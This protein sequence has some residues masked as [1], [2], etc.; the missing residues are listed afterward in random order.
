M[1]EGSIF[2]CLTKSTLR[3]R[4]GVFNTA[5]GFIPNHKTDTH[6]IGEDFNSVLNCKT[7]RHKNDTIRP[8]MCSL[9]SRHQ[10]TYRLFCMFKTYWFRNYIISNNPFFSV[11]DAIIIHINPE[12]IKFCQGI[13]N[14][15]RLEASNNVQTVDKVWLNW[16]KTKPEMMGYWEAQMLEYL[17]TCLLRKT[18][19]SKTKTNFRKLLSVLSET[20]SSELGLY[21]YKMN[22]YKIKSL[23]FTN[24]NSKSQI[25]GSVH[26][27]K[28]HLQYFW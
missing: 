15:S 17:V 24:R 7:H 19:G 11:Y 14:C 2:F 16:R 27:F 9:F 23:P 28:R 25:Q 6:V 20:C 5:K 26:I 22:N 18:K 3:K 10:I 12:N 1:A 13:W 21:T 8:L 4:G